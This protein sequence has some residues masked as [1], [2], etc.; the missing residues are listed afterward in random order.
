MRL[1]TLLVLMLVC[2]ACSEAHTGG[3]DASAGSSGSAATGG[4]GGTGGVGGS[5]GVGGT[6]GT[7]GSGGTSGSSGTGGVSGVG[8]SGGSGAVAAIHECVMDTDCRLAGG[9]CDCVSIPVTAN[10]IGECPAI[11][12][13]TR[14]EALGVSAQCVLG[15]CVFDA[16]C[17]QT[18]VT[19]ERLPP[20][21]PAGQQPIVR[22]TCFGECIDVRECRSVTSC[23]ACAD[24]QAC[25]HWGV[26]SGSWGW[27]CFDMASECN[28]VPTCACMG[29]NVCNGVQCGDV[30]NN[31]SPLG[32]VGCYCNAC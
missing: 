8:G 21:C 15:R 13:Q 4:D 18:S 2:V 3:A 11:C 30:D 29:E 5:G 20:V 9:C 31:G 19:C 14:C 1:R 23:G 6:S 24:N 12:D 10:G 26:P 7:S 22:N 27:H 25:L 16:T 17:D 28:G 32:H